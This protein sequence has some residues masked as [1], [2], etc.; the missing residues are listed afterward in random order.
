MDK[1]RLRVRP[2]FLMWSGA[3][4]LLLS[5]LAWFAA[6]G[7]TSESRAVA[8]QDAACGMLAY[9]WN[10]PVTTADRGFPREQPPRNNFNWTAPVNYAEGTLYFRAI[11]RSQPVAQSMK[12]QLCFWQPVTPD[13]SYKFG[14]E[15]CAQVKAIQG[16]SGATAEWNVP[17][18]ELW[19]LNGNLI[20][21]TRARYRTAV[22]IKNS[23]GEPV[24]NYS[25]WEWNGE[26]PAQWYPLDMHY[27]AVVVPVGG[28]FCGWDYYLGPSAVDFA[29][30]DG[31]T[32]ISFY[33]PLLAA[34]LLII[35]LTIWAWRR[36]SA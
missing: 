14:L 33:V 23:A 36:R 9:D 30:L 2:R 19:K 21:W 11:I 15:N 32:A 12:L 29:G 34:L 35:P 25:G 6:P 7:L 18:Q 20:D 28:Q 17:V 26:N 4:L 3:V 10:G 27:T 13:A 24:S 31:S 1:F 16:T 8:Q 5:V 22:A